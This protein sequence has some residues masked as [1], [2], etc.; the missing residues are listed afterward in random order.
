MKKKFHWPKM[1][2]KSRK[3]EI[4]VSFLSVCGLTNLIMMVFEL[5]HTIPI[6]FG[7]KIQR[8]HSVNIL[9]TLN[10]VN[11]LFQFL[12]LCSFHSASHTQDFVSTMAIKCSITFCCYWFFF[13]PPLFRSSTTAEIAEER[14]VCLCVNVFLLRLKIRL[15]NLLWRNLENLYKEERKS[16]LLY[17]NERKHF[18]IQHLMRNTIIE[19][20]HTMQ[21]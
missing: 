9:G 7:L 4:F 11:F 20:L 17:S 1:L 12:F 18:D 14:F 13:S 2:N 16:F 19:Y 15:D 5:F 3:N 10:I 6:S 21:T 8:N